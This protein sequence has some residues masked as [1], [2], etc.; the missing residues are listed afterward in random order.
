[1]ARNSSFKKGRV[2]LRGREV[3]ARL[4]E[5]RDLTLTDCFFLVIF[6]G[7]GVEQF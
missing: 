1:M 7:M 2:C 5:G 6:G 4:G 3:G